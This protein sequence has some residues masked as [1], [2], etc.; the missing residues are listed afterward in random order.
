MGRPAPPTN[1]SPAGAGKGVAKFKR[2]MSLEGRERMSKV[3]QQRH[4][5]GDG[6]GFGRGLTKP[7]TPPKRKHRRKTRV[8]E[9]V[10]QAAREKR[11]A[12]AIIDVFRDGVSDNQ[13]MHIRLKAAEAWLK[14]E[15]DD[16]KLR[17]QEE[18]TNSIQ[19]DRQELLELLA[20]KFTSGTTGLLLRRQLAERADSEILDVIE[21]EAE[22][23]EG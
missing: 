10:A 14:V 22:D 5:Q 9:Q 15:S 23:V 8:A 18:E 3:A 4:Q 12:D 21:V 2:T 17:L 20:G 13:P 1:L 19:R 6:H 7:G 16:A 11:S